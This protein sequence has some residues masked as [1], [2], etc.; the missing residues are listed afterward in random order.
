MY[1]VYY[2]R[3]TP[4]YKL[5]LTNNEDDKHDLFGESLIISKTTG[6]ESPVCGSRTN[7][8]FIVETQS[9]QKTV[10]TFSYYC[11]IVVISLF[12]SETWIHQITRVT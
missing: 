10:K 4:K 6:K 9:E 5:G 12:F 2:L 11:T 7:P 1:E 8:T 3:M